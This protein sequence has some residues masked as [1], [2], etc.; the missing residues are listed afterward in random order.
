MLEGKLA[1][2]C[3][4]YYRNAITFDTKMNVL[5]C[6]MFIEKKLGQFG[7]EFSS[8]EE[9][10]NHIESDPYKCTMDS[11]SNMP[12]EECSSCKY[13]ESCYGGCPVLWKNYS[14]SALQSFKI[15]YY[16]NR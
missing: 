5:P 11:L 12:S 13:F 6:N 7:K 10:Q 9:F 3:Q 14:Y 16:A 8:F 2:P 1:A 4:I 15:H